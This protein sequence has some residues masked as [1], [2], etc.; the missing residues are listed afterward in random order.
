MIRDG[1]IRIDLIT[2]RWWGIKIYVRISGL[3]VEEYNRCLRERSF[4][5]DVWYKIEY[6]GST[7]IFLTEILEKFTV[8]F[9]EVVSN[10]TVGEIRKA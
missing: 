10:K 2:H 9:V 8:E 3:I 1:S 7:E 6:Y 5:S 4:S